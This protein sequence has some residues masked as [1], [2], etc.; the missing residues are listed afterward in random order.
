MNRAKQKRCTYEVFNCI[1]EQY[2]DPTRVDLPGR[3]LPHSTVQKH[4][5]QEIIYQAQKRQNN[6]DAIF[7]AATMTDRMAVDDTSMLSGQIGD[8]TTANLVR[9]KFWFKYLQMEIIANGIMMELCQGRRLQMQKGARLVNVRTLRE[10]VDDTIID[11]IEQLR[12]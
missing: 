9:V 6:L 1:N 10:N 3:L 2:K 5:Q 8:G 12:Q 4:E 11:S 7:I